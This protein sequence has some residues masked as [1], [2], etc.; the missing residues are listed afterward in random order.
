MCGRS[1][2][3]KTEKEIEARFHATFYSEE[4]ERYNPLPNFNVAPT[5][6]H[7]V[8]TSLEP[9]HIH[10]Y[11]WG[12]IPF[13]AKDK[14]IGAKM[15]NARIETLLEKSAFKSLLSSKRCLVPLD[16]FY[17]WKTEGKIKT[18]FRITTK[19]QDIFSAAGLWDRWSMPDTGEIMH[20]FTIITQPPNELMAEIHDRMPSI[21]SNENER[22]WLDS[23]LNAGDAIQLL[24]PYPAENMI[25]YEVSKNVNNV[26]FNDPSLIEPLKYN[27]SFIQTRIF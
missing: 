5:Q 22:L 9:D 3:T 18:P 2:L 25:A 7:P 10:L 15:I 17:E 23:E 13:W 12:L 27:P 1:S 4:L 20:S 14:N 11:R 21:L 6:I 24:V 8:I 19:D 26:R 16:G